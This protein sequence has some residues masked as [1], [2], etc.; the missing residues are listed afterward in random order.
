MM[1][2]CPQCGTKFE[3]GARFCQECGYDS[4]PGHAAVETNFKPVREPVVM[5]TSEPE[6]IQIPEPVPVPPVWTAEPVANQKAGKSR[7]RIVWLVTGIIALAAA[8]WFGYNKFFAS[9]GKLP[10]NTVV[11]P[12]VPEKTGVDATGRDTLTSVPIKTAAPEQPVVKTKPP[13]T[14]GKDITKP[15]AKVTTQQTAKEK[16]E[17]ARQTLTPTKQAVPDTDEKKSRNVAGKDNK[18]KTL[19]NV[20][21]SK[22]PKDKNP[23]NPSKLVIQKPTMIVRII[24]DHYNKGQGTLSAGT[25]SIKDSEGNT[26]GTFSADGIP[27]EKG[28]PNVKWVAEPNIVLEK[29]TYFIWDSDMATWS[30]TFTGSGFIIVEGY[31][32]K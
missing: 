9:S 27:G 11:N 15:K 7:M 6:A 14:A 25:L 21:I 5:A 28:I 13:V 29:G 26:V 17:P 4:N 8:G 20:G 19:I 31:E 18:T 2:F 3:P 30:K 12:V 24:T 23:K 1:K 22:T 16:S 10:A 32:I